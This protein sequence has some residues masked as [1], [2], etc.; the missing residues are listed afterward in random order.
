V[1][2][3]IELYL[4][5]DLKLSVKVFIIDVVLDRYLLMY[6]LKI[7]YYTNYNY[8]LSLWGVEKKRLIR[9]LI[10]S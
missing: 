7:Y 4:Y 5:F 8:F 1:Y 2:L 6:V 3:S 10:D 9:G